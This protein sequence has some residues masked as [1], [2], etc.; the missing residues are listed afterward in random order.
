MILKIRA[1]AFHIKNGKVAAFIFR[2]RYSINCRFFIVEFYRYEE[3]TP[4]YNIIT[5]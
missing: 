5:Y 1:V 3:N 4:N 2:K